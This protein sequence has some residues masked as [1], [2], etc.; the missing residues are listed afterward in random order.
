MTSKVIKLA[1]DYKCDSCH[2]WSNFA[3]VGD[4]KMKFYDYKKG[5][6]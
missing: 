5:D 3:K 6:Y 2:Y 4:L 1:D